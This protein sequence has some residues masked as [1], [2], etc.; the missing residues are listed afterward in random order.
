[1][2]HEQENSQSAFATL[3]DDITA[4]EDKI[5]GTKRMVQA[6]SASSMEMLNSAGQNLERSTEQQE[7][8]VGKAS[9]QARGGAAESLGEIARY[10]SQLKQEEAADNQATM[11]MESTANGILGEL[12][13]DNTANQMDSEV[14]GLKKKESDTQDEESALAD[15]ANRVVH[16]LATKV[17]RKLQAMSRAITAKNALLQDAARAIPEKF[18]A[19]EQKTTEDQ[20]SITEIL[21]DLYAVTSELK[22]QV[23]V[24]ESKVKQVHE[25]NEQQLAS[26]QGMSDYSDADKISEVL[27]KLTQWGDMDA[28]IA[29][30]LNEEFKPKMERW[31]Q[32]IALVFNQ[33]GQSLSLEKVEENANA[34]MAE[35]EKMQEEMQRAKQD[36]ENF[37]KAQEAMQGQKE[38]ELAKK[39]ALEIQ[40]VNMDVSL[41]ASE[42]MKK[43]KSIEAMGRAQ[44][45]EINELANRMAEDQ[46]MVG[47]SIKERKEFMDQ[48]LE[49][50]NRALK[51]QQ[52]P[53]EDNT[54]YMQKIRQKLSAVEANLGEFSS[55]SSF[56]EERS[57]STATSKHSASL[58]HAAVLAERLAAKMKANA[59]KSDSAA[60]LTRSFQDVVQSLRKN[61]QERDQQVE[62]WESLLDGLDQGL[63]KNAK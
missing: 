31:Y 49:R 23:T 29:K 11:D 22:H 62:K 24:R 30:T 14:E 45:T 50:A 2:A 4:S 36:L 20:D 63:Q 7:A 17:T 56:L 34:R 21:R 26:M 18:D 32:G 27:T 33:L 55:A 40:K 39:I 25:E 13:S 48:M 19:M 16:S 37:L 5:S 42:K 52:N 8:A 51:M 58:E 3:N 41:S 46:R 61:D 6:A 59:G 44:Q 57:N 10:E 15:N 35:Q 47:M 43:I 12:N 1:M 9:A 60:S 28:A 38:R 54:A 53:P